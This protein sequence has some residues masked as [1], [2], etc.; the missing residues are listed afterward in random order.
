MQEGPKIL[1]F[2]EIAKRF[3]NSLKATFQPSA[4]ETASGCGGK[5]PEGWRSPRRR[6]ESGSVR[7]SARSWSAPALWRFGKEA[8]LSRIAKELWPPG[9]KHLAKGNDSAFDL[10]M[11]KEKWELIM[12]RVRTDR[13]GD[14][15]RVNAGSPQSL[16]CMLVR[17]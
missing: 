17:S 5:A 11:S 15:S 1:R 12:N 8:G 7:H 2:F 13:L 4:H 9:G 6:R 3:R 14:K 16:T 10:R